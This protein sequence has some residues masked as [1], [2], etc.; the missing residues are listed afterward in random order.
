MGHKNR[1]LAFSHIIRKVAF[2]ILIKKVI[3]LEI[4]TEL[5]LDEEGIKLEQE[6]ETQI[7]RHSLK[8][9][10]VKVLIIMQSNGI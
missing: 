8:L 6:H 9:V 2:K 1:N 4:F 3:I 7:S 5:Y 10:K